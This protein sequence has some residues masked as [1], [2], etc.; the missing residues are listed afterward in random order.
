MKLGENV[1]SGRN[2]KGLQ[3]PHH[4]LS[5]LMCQSLCYTRL[6]LAVGSSL[7]FWAIPLQLWEEFLKLSA[8]LCVSATLSSHSLTQLLPPASCIIALQSPKGPKPG[9]VHRMP[10]I[11][12]HEWEGEERD[13]KGMGRVTFLSFLIWRVHWQLG[14]VSSWSCIHL[15]SV[16]L[17]VCTCF[18]VLVCTQGFV[19]VPLCVLL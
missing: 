7:P 19:W 5:H 11:M 9:C 3:F 2:F 10:S 12:S 14:T 16:R 6:P 18:H 17:F 1:R 15:Y 8:Y 13:E 4:S